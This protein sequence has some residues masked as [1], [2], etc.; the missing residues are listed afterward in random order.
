MAYRTISAELNELS[1]EMIGLAIKVHNALG[2]GL[3]ESSY[4]ECLYYEILNTGHFVEK[5][6]ALPLIYKTINLDI[7]YRI[8]LLVEKKLIIE[9][10]STES[11][12]DIHTAQVLTYLKLS[13]NRIGLLINFNVKLLKEGIRRLVL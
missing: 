12:N 11:L 6:K 9:I 1:S 13:G 7:G 10:K 3:L 8:D 4:K 2:P 5:E